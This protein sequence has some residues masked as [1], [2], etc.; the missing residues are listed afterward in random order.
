MDA[1]E[2]VAILPRYVELTAWVIFWGG[3]VVQ[4][5]SVR[6]MCRLILF[7]FDKFTSEVLFFFGRPQLCDR[8]GSDVEISWD[9][10][11]TLN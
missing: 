9:E 2:K 5:R 3:V 1:W 7:K 10:P 8:P 6:F 11:E 4:K